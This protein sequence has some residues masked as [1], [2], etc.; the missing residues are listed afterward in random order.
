M[1]N[2][3]AQYCPNQRSVRLNGLYLVLAC[4]IIHLIFPSA[5]T[6]TVVKPYPLNAP[7][8]FSFGD[9]PAWSR[10]T[11]DDSNW[12]TFGRPGSRQPQGVQ[13]ALSI[14]W[15]RVRLNSKDTSDFHRPAIM[16]G[17]IGAA[18]EVFVNGVKVGGEGAVGKAFVSA[19]KVERVYEIPR[20]LLTKGGDNIIAA[21]VMSHLYRRGM[22][23]T[24]IVLGEYNNLYNEKLKCQWRQKAIELCFLAFLVLYVNYCL[25]VY[26]SGIKEKKYAMFGLMALIY[27]LFY[28][29]NSLF[30]MKPATKPTWFNI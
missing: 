8:K 6:T 10:P 24:N 11:F 20:E 21:R 4:L 23:E 12:L 29:L 28:L 25:F 5:A 19:S 30:F 22:P 18:D 1:G 27:A 17:R 15:Y 2:L 13:P 16:L 14:A 7:Y 9:D 3:A 26:L